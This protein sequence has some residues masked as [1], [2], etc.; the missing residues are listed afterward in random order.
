MGI[1]ADA[2]GAVGNLIGDV[3]G[4]RN[5]ITKGEQRVESA[6]HSALG[7]QSP[8][9]REAEQAARMAAM[10]KNDPAQLAQFEAMRATI[11]GKA[12]PATTASVEQQAKA[13]FTDFR[14]AEIANLSNMMPKFLATAIVDVAIPKVDDAKFAKAI[15]DPAAIKRLDM[16]E[17]D[18][19]T[20]PVPATPAAP[21]LP[22]SVRGI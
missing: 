21:P 3:E 19:H 12:D 22:G 5:A 4:V 10:L 15:D 9:Q 1:I 6:I 13:S 2:E 17:A 20:T 7:I 14:H 18:L 16:V 8:E 11:E